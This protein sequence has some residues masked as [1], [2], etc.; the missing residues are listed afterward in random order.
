M[1]YLL[2]TV[3]TKSSTDLHKGQGHSYQNQIN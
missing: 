2:N 3:L 1:I